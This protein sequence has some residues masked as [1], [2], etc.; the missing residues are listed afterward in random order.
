MNRPT[1]GWLSSLE[2]FTSKEKQATAGS[3]RKGEIMRFIHLACAAL[4]LSATP[5]ASAETAPTIGP[6]EANNSASTEA[7][8][9]LEHIAVW[10]EDLKKTAKFLDEALGWKTHPMQFG[11]YEDNDRFGGMDLAFVDANG[12][13]IELIQP[14]TPGPGLDLLKA[15]GKGAI[16]ELDFAVPNLDRATKRLRLMGIE[17]VGMDGKP[18]QDGGLLNEWVLKDGK[19]VD[20][21]ERL[22]YI[23]T[24][25]TRG[26]QIELFWEYPNGAL[27]VRDEMWKQAGFMGLEDGPRIDH[28]TILAADLQKSTEVYTK[29]LG[30][31]RSPQNN[32]VRRDWLGVGD[33]N[34]AWIRGN[35]KGF[36][37]QLIAPPTTKAGSA[38]VD[39]FTDG[40]IMEIGVEVSDLSKFY[41]QMKTK[42]ITL[43]TGNGQALTGRKKF[44]TSGNQLIR[45][46]YFPYEKSEGM[47]IM[48]F[49]RQQKNLN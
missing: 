3:N 35:E 15:K 20:A 43:T 33:A 11:V 40:N 39:K 41:D 28:V 36:D 19:R 16:V 2:I 7:T 27:N 12:I 14:T 13:W 1:G 38:L 42:G 6:S 49:Q 30:L 18:M 45:Y 31:T 8:P 32:G 37:I 46:A 21:D 34:S 47:R 17:A 24:E 23:P 48:V 9:Q 10:T 5:A 25:V 26:T 4:M 44:V 22:A 29:V